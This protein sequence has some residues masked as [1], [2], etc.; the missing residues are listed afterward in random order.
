MQSICWTGRLLSRALWNGI[1]NFSSNPDPQS[2]RGSTNG[3]KQPEPYLLSVACGFPKDRVRRL[4]KGQFG[5]DAWFS[6]KC[7]ATADVL[8]MY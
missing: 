2:V 3:Q 4:I 7:N 1:T 5:D 8:G 6:T